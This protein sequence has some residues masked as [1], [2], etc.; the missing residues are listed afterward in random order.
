MAFINNN[1]GKLSWK[2]IEDAFNKSLLQMN[3]I[4]RVEREY[5]EMIN[6]LHTDANTTD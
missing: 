2:E 4:E 5:K 1:Y 6:I 3:E